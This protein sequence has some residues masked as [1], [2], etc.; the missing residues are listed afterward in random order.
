LRFKFAEE[1]ETWVNNNWCGGKN[2]FME[3]EKNDMLR[4]SNYLKETDIESKFGINL[5]ESKNNFKKFYNQYDVRRN[6]N[7]VEVFPLIS[8]MVL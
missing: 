8:Q 5:I 6:K 2:Y 7:F 4:L 1:I 3:W